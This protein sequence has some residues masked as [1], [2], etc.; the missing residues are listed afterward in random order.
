M[1]TYKIR[2]F[3]IS[4]KPMVE[5]FFNQMGGESR[6]FF[7]RGHG[8]R[9]DAMNFFD[10]PN[11]PDK[12]R[13]ACTYT[14]DGLS[15]EQMAGYLFLWDI[16]KPVIWLGIAVRDSLKGQGVGTVLMEHAKS[17]AKKNCKGAIM[18]T[19]HIANVRGQSLYQKSGYTNLGTH[20]SGEMLY[21]LVL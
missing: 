20:I 14:P 16:T 8:N 17:F 1:N 5:E 13:F 2:P 6:G 3:A 19:T 18:L 9:D 10:N 11:N 4:D 12:I 7:D 21:M 15:E